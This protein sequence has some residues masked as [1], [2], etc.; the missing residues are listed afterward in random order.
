MITDK[1]V[2]KVNIPNFDKPG[3][4]DALVSEKYMHIDVKS[5]P[6]ARLQT[7]TGCVCSWAHG[8]SFHQPLDCVYTLL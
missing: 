7:P 3:E 6:E 8:P 5:G 4:V 1:D 2:C